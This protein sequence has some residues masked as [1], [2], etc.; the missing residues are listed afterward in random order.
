LRCFARKWF[1]HSFFEGC[2]K[3]FGLCKQIDHYCKVT[4]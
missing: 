3:K 2:E 4:R 1:G